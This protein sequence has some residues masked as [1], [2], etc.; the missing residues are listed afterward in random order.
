[1]LASANITLDGDV[2]S[3]ARIFVYGVAPVPY[4]STAAE[5]T[6]TGKR[7]NLETA[8]SAGEAAQP[9]RRPCR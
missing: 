8:A 2:V 1:M 4:R 7:V 5:N 9:A 3:S 6:I